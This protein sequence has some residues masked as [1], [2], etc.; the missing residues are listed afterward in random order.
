MIAEQITVTNT[1]TSLTALIAAVRANSPVPELNNQGD[2]LLYYPIVSTTV[3][4]MG[5]AETVTPVEVLHG[6]TELINR[7]QFRDMNLDTTFLVTDT[8]TQ[9][10]D[11]VFDKG[12]MADLN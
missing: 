11:V 7:V 10:V 1:L 8:G 5:D 2:L 6:D 4:L 12:A 9:V 3:I